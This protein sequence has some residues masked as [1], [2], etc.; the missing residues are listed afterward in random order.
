MSPEASGDN[1]GRMLVPDEVT[2]AAASE[3]C[4]YLRVGAELTSVLSE[5][6]DD[7]LRL[8]TTGIVTQFQIGFW[9][10]TSYA[11]N[12]FR[13]LDGSPVGYTNWC[14][15]QPYDPVEQPFITYVT[16]GGKWTDAATRYRFPYVCKYAR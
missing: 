9:H 14:P 16:P 15:G 6:E 11:S 4:R 12:E 5:E 8:L 13:W 3:S 2:G 7:F 10:Q 1:G